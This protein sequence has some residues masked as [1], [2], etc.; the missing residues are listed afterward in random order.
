M[1]NAALEIHDR[2]Q[3]GDP[4]EWPL[5]LW[6]GGAIIVRMGLLVAAR[7]FIMPTSQA[8]IML[9]FFGPVLYVIP[10]LVWWVA[11][12]RARWYERVLIPPAFAIAGV[13]TFFFGHP[14]FHFGIFMYSIPAVAALWVLS[15]LVG[16]FLPALVRFFGLLLVIAL[17]WSFFI[18]LR[19][20]G[21][22]GS[23]SPE[24]SWRWTQTAEERYMAQRAA[25]R[26][27]GGENTILP[28][29]AVAPG[30]WQGFR[31]ATRDGRL[32]GVKIETDW[33]AHPPKEL[34]RHRIGPGW[35]SF[36]VIGHRVYTQEQR[37]KIEAVVCFDAAT[38]KEIWSHEVET[39][40]TED[41]S[42][43]GP[44]AT[45]TFH[46]GKIYA[47]QAK[48]QLVCLDAT[49][50][51]KLWGKEV[52]TDGE[53]EVPTWAFSSSPLVHDGIVTVFAGG[54]NGKA[55]LGYDAA[56]GDLK[57]FS[58]KGKLSYCSP[59]PAKLNG[60]D[61][62]LI[63]TDEGVQAFEPKSGEVLW[64]HN[65]KPMDGMARVV[66]PNLIG[67]SGD[68]LVGTGFGKGTRRLRAPAAGE[69]EAKEIWTTTAIS[70]YYNDFVVHKGFLYGFDGLFFVCVNLENGNGCWR[71]RGYG[72][73]QVL[74]LA[75]QD[76]LLVLSEKGEVALLEA[77]SEKR[78]ELGKFKA[79]KGKTWNHPV[80]AHGKLFVRNG[81]EIACFQLE[82]K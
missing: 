14:S 8:A 53:A 44:R 7:S 20:E 68:L 56:S 10:L 73:G 6:P 32:K 31:G 33:T 38:G 43:A 35:S 52:T 25:N 28:T 4:G 19:M 17:G 23:F 50:G 60:V 1:S 82:T 30:D 59:Q 63:T 57:W 78:V 62:V 58:G 39:R 16:Q 79:I 37:D 24:L 55:V 36:A 48:G 21:V 74:L 77:N 46:D 40:F 49:T 9:L 42:G 54:A 72:N 26:S 51:K 67:E 3:F 69:K 81:E 41:V 64:E 80:I 27:E 15:L 45:P 22:D 12:S 65:W 75:D 76:L 2:P 66:Q 61:Q 11:F 70:P 47:L 34:W 29:S 71:E 5:R 13:C 18:L